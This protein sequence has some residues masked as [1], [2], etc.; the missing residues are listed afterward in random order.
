MPH[1]LTLTIKQHFKFCYSWSHISLHST[2]QPT[3]ALNKKTIQYN[4]KT[5]FNTVSINNYIIRTRSA[6]LRQSIKTGTYCPHCHYQNI[7]ILQYTNFVNISS[8]LLYAF[9]WVI[10]QR[11]NFM[12]RRFGTLCSIFIG[13][14]RWNRQCVQK[15]GHI[16]FRPQGITQK[17]AYSIQN[18]AK[19]EIKAHDA[20]T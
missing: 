11:P 13:L 1:E 15:H 16:K 14:W 17:K 10:P 9:F 18:T 4:H 20:V 8:Q 3:K 2:H 6:I 7:K 5:Q 19:V 12:C